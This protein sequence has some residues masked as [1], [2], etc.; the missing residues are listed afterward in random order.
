MVKAVAFFKRRSGMAVEEFQAYWRTQH[1]EVVTKLRGMHRYVQSHTRL[2]A[3]RTGEPVYDGIAELWF[4]DTA[5][6]RALRDTPEMA[7]IQADEARFIDRSTMGLIITDDHV[8]KDGPVRPGMAK[9]IGFV[10]RKPGMLVEAFQRH[11]REVHGPLGAAI[12]TMRRYVQSHTRVAAYHREREPPWDGIAI[13]WFD[14]PAALRA[15]NTTPEWDRAKAD[16]ANFIAPGPVSFIVT[17]EHVI[18]G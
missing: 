14:D 17:T 3:Y 11:W 18:T 1:P 7:A 13:I 9:G 12:P 2:A 15:A 4:D 6:M 10:R 5:A 8:V 16:D